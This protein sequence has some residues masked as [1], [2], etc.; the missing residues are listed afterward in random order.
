MA[1]TALHYETQS[2]ERIRELIA[3]GVDVNEAD[4]EGMTPLH[5]ACGSFHYAA[6][7]ALLEAGATVDPQDKWGNTPLLRSVGDHPNALA[8][9]TL[10]VEY[11]ANPRIENKYG[12]SPL[13]DAHRMQG[14]EPMIPVLEAAAERFPLPAGPRPDLAVVRTQVA[15]D[16]VSPIAVTTKTWQE[17]FR[18]LWDLLVPLESAAPTEQGEVIRLAGRIGRETLNNG[19]I[20]WSRDYSRMAAALAKLLGSRTPVVDHAELATLKKALS[21][22]N[23]R[24]PAIDRLTELA[25]AWVLANPN[26]APLAPPPYQI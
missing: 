21:G 18:E 14:T 12:H 13:S 4:S 6:A 1:R 7:K 20:N 25:V 5:S 3:E 15:H 16:G 26:P 19:G 24:R 2:E 10:L 17:Q 11:G 9:A 22:G 23:A 8:L